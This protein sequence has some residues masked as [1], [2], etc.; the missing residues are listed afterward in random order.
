MTHQGRPT[1]VALFVDKYICISKTVA[2]DLEIFLKD[3]IGK[4]KKI[5]QISYFHLGSDFKN[6]NFQSDE[7]N[8]SIKQIFDRKIPIYL[9]VSTLEPRKN[10][11]YLLDVFD[12][13]WA[14]NNDIGLCIVGRIGWKVDE[15]MNRILR[16]TQLGKKLFMFNEA[17][18]ADVAYC[19]QHSNGLLFPS[20]VEGFGLPIIEGLQRGLPV[21]ASSTKI[22]KEVGQN[23]VTYFELSDSKSLELLI[24]DHLKNEFKYQ[25]Q[26]EKVKIINWTESAAWLW[27]EMNNR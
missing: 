17:S 20:I 21:F 18:D 10:H 27:K 23:M 13:L 9:I 7:V 19:Y 2:D 22:H 16:H 12:N 15:L 6:K 5:P 4:E 26:S 25:V 1:R 8:S 11:N 3:K 24:L 14:K